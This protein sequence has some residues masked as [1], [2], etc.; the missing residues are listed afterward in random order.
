MSN[1]VFH[2]G[3]EIQSVK[4]GNYYVQFWAETTSRKTAV[5]FGGFNLNE[6][7]TEKDFKSKYYDKD[8]GKYFQRGLKTKSNVDSSITNCKNK[9]QGTDNVYYEY[10]MIGEK[11]IAW[12]LVTLSGA[13]ATDDSRFPRFLYYRD[14]VSGTGNNSSSTIVYRLFRDAV[15]PSFQCDDRG[16]ILMSFWTNIRANPN[17]ADFTSDWRNWEI[18]DKSIAYIDEFRFSLDNVAN[19]SSLSRYNNNYL[20]KA[21]CNA[22]GKFERLPGSN[23]Y[24]DVEKNVD[25]S[26]MFSTD[27]FPI[28]EKPIIVGATLNEQDYESPSA[29]RGVPIVDFIPANEDFSCIYGIKTK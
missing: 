19:A 29:Y 20:F 1:G 6:R 8:S 5:A 17:G 18:T 28:F 21:R 4:V 12:Q 22:V 13:P 24:A 15:Y 14:V 3:R 23:G 25:S 2:I 7:I 16:S 26:T 9:N 11:V 27:I 10:P